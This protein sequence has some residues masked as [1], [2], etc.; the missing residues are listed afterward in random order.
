VTARAVFVD[1]GGVLE[2]TPATGWQARWEA[3]LGL[4]AGAIDERLA[5][6]WRDGMVG[7]ITEA[8]AESAMATR[9]GLDAAALA[10]LLAD[11]WDEYL[12]SPNQPL[13]DWFGALRPRVRTG[14]ISNSFVGARARE[15][16][17]YGF[18][19]RCDLLVYSHEVGLAKPGH[20]IYALACSRLE[21]S[22]EEA[23]FLDDV[24]E[25]VAAA[26]ALGMRA[27]LYRDAQSAIAELDSY[28]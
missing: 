15:E 22:P 14:I 21:V 18:A 2:L 11:S 28:L 3:S 24:A 19:A 1:I 12:G 20:A 16:A 5:D 7:H 26:A 25:N 4:P 13:I 9:L 10:R 6:V 17:R 8:E 27:V 23:L